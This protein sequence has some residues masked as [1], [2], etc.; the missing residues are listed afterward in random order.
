MYK[1]TRTLDLNPLESLSFGSIAS[2]IMIARRTTTIMT[3]S[4]TKRYLNRGELLRDARLGA[5]IVSKSCKNVE[6]WWLWGR[7][8]CAGKLIKPKCAQ[9]YIFVT[10]LI[11]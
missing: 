3:T 7:Y 6:I 4:A 1:G 9:C 8:K 2:G 5:S 10:N 11:V